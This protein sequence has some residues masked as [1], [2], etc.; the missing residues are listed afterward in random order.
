MKENQPKKAKLFNPKLFP[1]DL[2]RVIFSPLPLVFRV[3]RLTPDGK[4]YKGKIRGGAIVAANHNAFSDS[5]VL[6]VAFWYRRLFFMVADVVMKTKLRAALIRGIGGIE[7]VR[8]IADLQAIKKAVGVLKEG[9]L[10]AI[11][12]QGR[13]MKQGEVD[14]VKHGTVLMALQAGVPIYPTY[15][16]P[17][18]HFFSRY[19]VVIG[20]PIYPN[21]LCK[22]KIPSTADIERI[23]EVL[24]QEMNRCNVT[25]TKT[26]EKV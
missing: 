11:F 1:M 26:E 17:R 21:E 2:A 24:R 10:L 15:I 18:K 22:R 13:I 3:R 8:E 20:D 4:K 7:I 16:Y 25:L 9:H 23:S 14:N 5:M 12:P 6:F 19:T